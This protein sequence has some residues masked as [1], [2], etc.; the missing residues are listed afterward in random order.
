MTEV[1]A[2]ARYT[3]DLQASICYGITYLSVKDGK[4]N[5]REK[6]MLLNHLNKV[7]RHHGDTS[8]LQTTL[9]ETSAHPLY[10]CPCLCSAAALL[11]CGLAVAMSVMPCLCSSH[12]ALAHVQAHPCISLL[13]PVLTSA[14][15]LC[16]ADNAVQNVVQRKRQLAAQSSPYARPTRKQKTAAPRVKVDVAPVPLPRQGNLILVSG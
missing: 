1:P 7:A 14:L 8:N 11:C 6:R 10:L 16:P 12:D 5:P 15:H 2:S 4:Y 9:V 3:I 13:P